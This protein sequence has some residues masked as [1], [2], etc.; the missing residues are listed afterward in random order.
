[1]KADKGFDD[2]GALD[3]HGGRTASHMDGKTLGRHGGNAAA[4]LPRQGP[5]IVPRVA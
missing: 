4:H 2:G 1:M 3:M 5:A